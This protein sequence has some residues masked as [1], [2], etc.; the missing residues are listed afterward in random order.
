MVIFTQILQNYFILSFRYHIFD[1]FKIHMITVSEQ[2][3]RDAIPIRI[4]KRKASGKLLENVS[5]W[6]SSLPQKGEWLALKLN[7]MNWYRPWWP[8]CTHEHD[9]DV[10]I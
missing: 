3:P 4:R 8:G 5:D 7:Q 6:L 9:E 1:R 2:P 10:Q